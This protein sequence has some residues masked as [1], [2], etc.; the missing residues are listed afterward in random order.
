ML[1]LKSVLACKEVQSC[2]AAS[3]INSLAADQSGAASLIQQAFGSTV[4]T[5]RSAMPEDCKKHDRRLVDGDA[6]LCNRQL[7]MT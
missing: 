7:M 5:L 3:S 6:D 4:G 2:V 1:I